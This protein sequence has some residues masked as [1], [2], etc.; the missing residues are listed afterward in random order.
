[1]VVNIKNY[2]LTVKTNIYAHNCYS[3][4]CGVDENA[5]CTCAA[6]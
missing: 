5:M 6:S 2:K 1:M 4:P 3:A